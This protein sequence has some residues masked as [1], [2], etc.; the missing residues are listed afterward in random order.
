M[1]LRLQRRCSMQS[2]AEIGLRTSAVTLAYHQRGSAMERTNLT[3]LLAQFARFGG[4]AA[5]VQRRGYRRGKRT[6]TEMH[7]PGS[8]WNFYFGLQEGTAAD[9]ALL[10]GGKAAG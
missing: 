2:E 9:P 3:S 10:L 6:N 8:F 5:V 1:A 4:D 7:P